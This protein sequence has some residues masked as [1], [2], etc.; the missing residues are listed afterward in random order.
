MEIDLLCTGITL[1]EVPYWWDKKWASLA[2]TIYNVR[3]D[4]FDVQPKGKEISSTPPSQALNTGNIYIVL[5]IY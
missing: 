5:Y 1:I 4:L 3:P 2:K